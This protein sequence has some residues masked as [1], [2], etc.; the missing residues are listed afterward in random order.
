VR[1]SEAVSGTWR[2]RPRRRRHSVKSSQD[3]SPVGGPPKGV[4]SDTSIQLLFR[5]H[6]SPGRGSRD[7]ASSRIE[8][9][10]RDLSGRRR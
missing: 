10:C 1:H 5:S 6:G 7:Y 3:V 4:A 8:P 9:G 2:P